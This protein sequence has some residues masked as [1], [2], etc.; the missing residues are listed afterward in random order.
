MTSQESGIPSLSVS[1]GGNGADPEN[2]G[3]RA[4]PAGFVFGAAGEIV[5]LATNPSSRVSIGSRGQAPAVFSS[6]LRSWPVGV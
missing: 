4:S 6:T 3:R 5:L 2:A 1:A